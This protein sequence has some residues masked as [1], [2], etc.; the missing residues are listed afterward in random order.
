MISFDG[1]NERDFRSQ[2]A[3]KS[4]FPPRIHNCAKQWGYF[5]WRRATGVM[6]Q[7]SPLNCGYAQASASKFSRAGTLIFIPEPCRLFLRNCSRRKT[8][9]GSIATGRVWSIASR[10]LNLCHQ[11]RVQAKQTFSP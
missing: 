3:L 7:Q 10:C 2:G 5:S 9:D 11:S 6:R 4:L 1:K 8:D